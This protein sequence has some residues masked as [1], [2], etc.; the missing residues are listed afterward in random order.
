M[1]LDSTHLNGLNS[2]SMDW[3]W[4]ILGT[5][6]VTGWGRGL[7]DQGGK[8]WLGLTTTT[9]GSWS[10]GSFREIWGFGHFLVSR[11]GGW[12]GIMKERGRGEFLSFFKKWARFGQKF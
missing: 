6:G 10:W 3:V 9:T 11:E 5:L 2:G 4:T 8:G 12:R 1:G 7:V